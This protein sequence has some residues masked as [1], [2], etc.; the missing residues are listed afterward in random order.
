MA[1]G[2]VFALALKLDSHDGLGHS[3]V[4]TG[5]DLHNLAVHVWRDH[6]SV[7][8]EE[9]VLEAGADDVASSDQIANLQFGRGVVPLLVLVERGQLDSSRDKD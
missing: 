7:F 6:D 4:A 1:H 2:N 3:V 5:H 9:L 8:V